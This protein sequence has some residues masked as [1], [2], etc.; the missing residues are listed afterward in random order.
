MP[1]GQQQRDPRFIEISDDIKRND[2]QALIAVLNQLA[3][4]QAQ[5]TVQRTLLSA[6]Q[7]LSSQ[8]KNS[9]LPN[10][11]AT[12]VRH[13][14]KFAY[15]KSSRNE[16]RGACLQKLDCNALKFCG[17]AYT[18]RDLL[19]L[20]DLHFEV[21]MEY[22]AEFVHCRGLIQY[23]YRSDINKALDHRSIAEDELF[24]GF[25][26]ESAC[27]NSRP[28]KR[29]SVVNEDSSKVSNEPNAVSTEPTVSVLLPRKRPREEDTVSTSA[30]TAPTRIA[31]NQMSNEWSLTGD[32]FKLTIN[33]VK[34]VSE[35][36]Q[37]GSDIFLTMPHI[38]KT[39][40]FVTVPVSNS[41]A[42]NFASRRSH[43]S[44]G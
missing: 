34:E 14:V 25:L 18:V 11:L 35:S 43:L 44:S 2:D 22:I 31:S 10:Q 3:R 16:E 19:G 32:V 21:L 4:L 37:V 28:I 39:A 24:R 23:L 27:L 38:L 36:D 42:L 8:A 13:I 1:P 15:E 7:I 30:S 17:L 12:R 5:A 29:L 26:N 20:P 6:A 41:L 9:A 33:D 40:P